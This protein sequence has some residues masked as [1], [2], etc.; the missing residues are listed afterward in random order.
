MIRRLS[1]LALL[2]GMLGIIPIGSPAR[3][4]D[5]VDA[6]ANRLFQQLDANRD[7]RLSEAD[8]SGPQ[9]QFLAR[10]LSTSGQREL[11]PDAFRELF[12]NV[13]GG[14]IRPAEANRG[15]LPNP[16]PAPPAPAESAPPAKSPES[17]R[18]EKKGTD[19]SSQRPSNSRLRTSGRRGTPAAPEQTLEGLWRG[20]VV[21]DD[22][23]NP[24]AG[25]M[26]IEVPF[27]GNKVSAKEVGT[28]RAPG[29]LGSGTFAANLQTGF[30]DAVG[31]E[32]PQ[33]DR[34]FLGIFQ[35]Q[36]DTLR[37]CSG[38]HRRARPTEYATNRGNYLMVLRR[39]AE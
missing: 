30:I 33:A 29:G 10:V 4:Q 16:S 18:E 38:N 39:M 24:N 20:W 31:T 15:P 36:G 21:H 34:Q 6:E 2:G 37:W 11:T 14:R 1:L 13:R 23:S 19:S 17:P 35:L 12:R 8:A 3:A 5:P 32:G 27:E 9:G 26:Q 28:Q 25:H 7:G 22:G